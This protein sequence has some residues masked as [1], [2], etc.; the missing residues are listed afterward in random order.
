[1]STK[2]VEADSEKVAVIREW[3]APSTVK[4]VQGFLGFCNFYRRFIK[5]YGRIARPLN[6]L[7]RKGMAFKWTAQC[8]EAFE[9]L[10]RVMLEAPI[11][12]YFDYELDTMV[13]TD[14]SDG[15]VAGV[16]S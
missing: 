6:S 8:Q 15:V 7:T 2:G 10:K 4:G 13:E 5:E 1:M 12:R 16:L 3:R 9:Q 11:L 14:A